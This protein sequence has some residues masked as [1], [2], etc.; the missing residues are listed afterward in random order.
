VGSGNFG[1]R[2]AEWEFWIAEWETRTTAGL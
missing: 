2:I 1:M